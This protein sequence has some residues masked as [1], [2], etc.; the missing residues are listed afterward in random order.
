MVLTNDDLSK[1]VET[2]DEWIAART[3]PHRTCLPA[4]TGE[5]R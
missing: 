3:G 1:L 2:N 4:L 5:E